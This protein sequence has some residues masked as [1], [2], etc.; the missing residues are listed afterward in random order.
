MVAYLVTGY[1]FE[2]LGPKKS[3]SAS[4]GMAFLGGIVLLFVG[5]DHQSSW[6]FV[7]QVILAKFG[8]VATQGINYMAHPDMFPTLFSTTSMGYIFIIMYIYA[9]VSNFVT[10]IEEPVPLI[11]FTA[12]SGLAAIL[13]IFLRLDKS[14]DK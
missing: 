4:F 2:F 3:Y 5:L 1:I 12:S 9:S 8:I 10:T 6:T 7:L 11:I 14:K 13:P